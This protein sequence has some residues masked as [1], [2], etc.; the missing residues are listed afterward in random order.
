M[1]LPQSFQPEF[2][3]NTTTAISN[4]ADKVRALT[5][6]REAGILCPM[7]SRTI[8][9]LPSSIPIL[10]RG[11]HGSQGKDIVVYED[12]TK[13]PQ[14]N[15]HEFYSVYIPNSREYRIHVV[16]GEIIRIQG[17]YCD[18]PEQTGDGYIKNHSHGYRFR[19]PDKE[20]NN[21]RKEA[22]INAV[23]ALGLDFGA[24]DL[25]IG[26]DRKAYV[27]EVNTAPAM[28]PMTLGEYVEAFR[29]ILDTNKSKT[30]YPIGSVE[31]YAPRRR[32]STVSVAP[33]IPRRSDGLIASRRTIQPR[34]DSA[35]GTY[36]G[37]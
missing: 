6:M 1:D 27:L 20:L 10:G 2:T 23:E 26:T 24:V 34:W 37:R 18:F 25:I 3:I 13:I 16:R 8:T 7:F 32:G 28:S 33:S 5:L 15:S 17:K 19:T 22:A 11:R 31:P 12:K 36:R 9:E 35:Y 14:S 21:D 30:M 29:K 4:A